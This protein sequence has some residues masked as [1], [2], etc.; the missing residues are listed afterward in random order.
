MKRTI[1]ALV[2]ATS[3]VCGVAAHAETA[4]TEGD[5]GKK[6]GEDALA[7]SHDRAMAL[8]K[9]CSDFLTTRQQFRFFAVEATIA[10]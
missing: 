7:A 3:L 1:V 2:L 9:K 10:L 5:A 8:L 4:S 6:A